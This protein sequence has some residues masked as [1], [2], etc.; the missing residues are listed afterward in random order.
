[1]KIQYKIIPVLAIMQLLWGVSIFAQPPDTLWTKTYGG[2]SLDIGYWIEQTSEGGYIITGGTSSFGIGTPNNSN[3]YLIKTNASGD[4]LWTKTFGGDSW[5]GGLSVQQTSDGGYIIVGLTR[6]FGASSND[7]YLIKTNAN[8]DTLWTRTYGG[9][10]NDIGRSVRETYDKGYIIT[11]Y[12]GYML[13][14]NLYLIKTDSFGNKLWQ[15]AFGDSGWTEGFSVE[16]CADSGY[17][18][19][20]TTT[21]LGAG[22]YDV[23]L[24]RTNAQGD[25]LWT[26]TYGGA[27]TDVGFSVKQTS[28]EGFIISGWTYLSREHGIDVYLIKTDSD[29]DTL[30]TRTYGDSSRKWEVGY[31]VQQTTDG[32]YIIGGC[33]NYSGY[34]MSDVYIIKTD[35]NGDTLWTATYGGANDDY[36]YLVQQTSDEGYIIA[37]YT[38]SF[39][40]GS[41]IYIIKINPEVSVEEKNPFRKP[42]EISKIK[43]NP[44]KDKVLIEFQLNQNCNVQ[45][46]IYNLF[47][48][49]VKTLINK[50]ED[51]G[52]HTI[53]WDGGDNSGNI[54]SK[55]VYF[56][57]YKE[58]DYISIR[59][60]IKN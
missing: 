42:V 49:M 46:V 26:K 55:G 18:V 52:T 8:G 30:W 23:Y 3:V 5:D 25:T 36:G 34:D 39:G 2:D 41:Q 9:E 13:Q 45:I 17:I 12:T 6:S 59:K 1:M 14:Y 31:S 57:R 16:E 22:G 35:V 54:V 15:K 21:S 51:K 50:K 24:I 60:I 19:T 47:G 32:G 53:T 27:Q 11:G 29:G 28:D 44:F 7:V 37:G 48:K 38:E 4:T 56:I 10:S 33:T 58:E 40:A 20:G 43:P